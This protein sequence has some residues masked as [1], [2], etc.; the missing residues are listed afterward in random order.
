[1]DEKGQI[2]AIT[3]GGETYYRLM[4]FVF[5]IYEFQLSRIDRELSELFE[6][7]SHE[8]FGGEFF[9][10][11]PALM[12]VLPINVEVPHDVVIEPY[13]SAIQLINGAKSWAV[14][15]CICKKE[16]ALLGHRCDKPM[17]VCLAFAPMEHVFDNSRSGRAITRDEAI[18]I[19]NIA[20]EAGLVH[21]TSNTKRGH[22]YI[23]N[24]CKCCCGPLLGYNLTSKHAV[25]KSN[26]VAVV[27]NGLCT[28]C[29][30]CADRC[31]AGA[32]TIGESA[33]IDNCIGCG[34]CASTCPEEA[35]KIVRRDVSD[36]TPV[37]NDEMEW[38]EERAR[39]RGIGRDYR[40]FID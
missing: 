34:L 20:E 37:P 5:G 10:H 6:A 7:Y 39:S 12:K 27:D 23:C 1:M 26:Y 3:I 36:T 25:A 22:F 29:G 15:D 8:A 4:P 2:F 13:E 11:T 32:V 35:I 19:L 33:K 18:A 16:K 24:C 17:E 38:L 21:M 31:Q 40:Q 30:I 9:S 28:A 14:H